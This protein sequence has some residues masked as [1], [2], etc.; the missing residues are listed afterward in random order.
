MPEQRSEV[1]RFY[2]GVIKYRK[3]I[4]IAFVAAAIISGWL[5]TKVYVDYNIMNYLPQGSPSMVS[6]KVMTEEF[7]GE[8]PN[9]RVVIRDAD[10]KTALE[11]KR[12]LEEM[13]GV[14]SVTWLDTMLPLN[15]P[16][17]MFPQSLLDTYFKDGNA[18]F[19]L[20]VDE[21]KQTETIP[22]IY[23]LIGEENMVSGTAV[24]TVVATLNT[25][26]E[27]LIITVIAIFFLLFV[28]AITTTSWVEPIVVMTGLGIA[29]VINSGTNII[30]GKISFV[31][32][33]A[34]MVLQMAVALDY[35]VF[36]I[37]RFTECLEEIGD[38][39]KAM[40]EA[41]KLST[42]SILSSGLT[43]VIGF[44]ALATMRFLIGADLGWALSKGIIISLITVL[45]F[46]PGL[47]LSTYKLMEKTRHRSFMPSFEKFGSFV[48]RITMPL[49]IVFALAIAPAFIGSINNSYLYG[50]SKIYGPETRCGSDA[51][52]IN[53]IFGY[54]DTYVLM[55]PPG[56]NSKESSLIREVKEYPEVTSVM[57]PVS[58]IGEAVPYE[59]LPD[60]LTSQL[61]S[62]NYDRIVMSVSLPSES[63]ETFAFVEKMYET[64]DRYYP[65]SYHLVSEGVNVN[66]LKNVI[67]SDNLKVNLVAIAAVFM[68]LVLTMRNLLLPLILVLVIETAIWVNMSISLITGTPLFYMSYLIVSS[69]QLGATVDYAILFAQRYRENRLT[70]GFT[71]RESVVKT[72][73]DNTVSIM[74]SG[75]AVSFMGF[76]LAIF[77]TQGIIAQIGLLLGR[78]TLCSL[79]LVLF[80]LP[81][82][83]MVFDRFVI[84]SFSFGNM[85]RSAEKSKKTA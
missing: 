44:L 61:R 1:D 62:E 84:H 12:K 18:M 20:T 63:E 68:I 13:D 59:A 66:D 36:L 65:G 32:N 28:L 46:M 49:T 45:V 39:E 81:G 70:L 29:V 37:H 72:I 9:C 3:A 40:K 4:M 33:S 24:L 85:F 56:D 80:V 21:D 14:I 22:A 78:G 55:V 75:L 41:L 50:S 16:V 69:V 11:Y 53:E 79:F 51:Q 71:P 5:A 54:R 15:M 74:T 17:E 57:S 7:G 76:L 52:K 19:L 48:C 82:L 34:G 77:S 35:S 10:R 31:T 26:K 38:P 64:A 23:D 58:V 73:S 60:T 47:I 8:V 6:L 25:V 67:T 83:L 30:F 43:T 27:I 42:S 2:G